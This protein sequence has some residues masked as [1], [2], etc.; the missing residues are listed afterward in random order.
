VK[1]K[2]WKKFC[3]GGGKI[4]KNTDKKIGWGGG[5]FTGV[6]GFWGVWGWVWGGCGRCFL[7]AGCWG[8]GLWWGG[9]VLW[10][11]C[12][13]FGEGAWGGWGVVCGVRWV[14]R[15]GC[16]GVFLCGSVG[17]GSVKWT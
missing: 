17:G 10:V 8:G 3:Q 14:E 5:G 15:G 1:R 9:G 12:G 4:Q 7:A 11:R 16:A 13:E 6:F 2:E